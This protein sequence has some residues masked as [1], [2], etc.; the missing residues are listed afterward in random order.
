MISFIEIFVSLFGFYKVNA[1]LII[2]QK[3]HFYHY[4]LKHLYKH[5]KSKLVA[6]PEIN[7]MKTAVS[8]VT[9]LR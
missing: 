8:S 2:L 5:Y 7:S 3:F 6:R 4:W 9:S 1:L